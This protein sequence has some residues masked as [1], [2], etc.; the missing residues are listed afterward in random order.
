VII[1]HGRI[2]SKPWLRLSDMRYWF[3]SV[4]EGLEREVERRRKW[5]LPS[6]LSRASLC[7]MITLALVGDTSSTLARARQ[8]NLYLGD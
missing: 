5:G 4:D 1:R 6:R 7:Y 8:R 3:D 2:T